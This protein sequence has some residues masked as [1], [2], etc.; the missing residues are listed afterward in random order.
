MILMQRRVTCLM[1]TLV[2]R[3]RRKTT[4]MMIML[5]QL[6]PLDRQTDK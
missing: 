5:R 4:M 1:K 2:M 6:K 3:K